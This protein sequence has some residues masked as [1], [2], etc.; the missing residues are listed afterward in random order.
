MAI[1]I[2]KYIV[3]SHI[4]PLSVLRRAPHPIHTRISPFSLGFKANTYNAEIPWIHILGVY[5]GGLISLCYF[6][7]HLG[8]QYRPN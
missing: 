2:F 8:G 3:C 4:Y 6:E 7:I 5:N 1:S